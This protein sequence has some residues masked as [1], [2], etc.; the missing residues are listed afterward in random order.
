MVA[1]EAT[2][3]DNSDTQCKFTIFAVSDKDEL[4]FITGT[5]QFK[6]NKVTFENSGFPIRTGVQIIAARVGEQTRTDDLIY[7]DDRGARVKQLMRD[8]VTTLWREKTLS[9]EAPSGATTFPAFVTTV[10]VKDIH[11][12]AVGSGFPLE[13]TSAPVH[14]TVNDRVCALSR[15]STTF[16]TDALGQV[17]IVT[18]ADDTLAAPVFEVTVR[19]GDKSSTN[20]VFAGQRV[21]ERLGAFKSGSD[22]ANA[23]AVDGTPV[24]SDIERQECSEGFAASGELLKS[25]PG[26]ITNLDTDAKALVGDTAPLTEK[27][28]AYDTADKAQQSSVADWIS[29]AWTKTTK[30]I[31]DALEYLRSAV[32]ATLKFAFKMVG[33]AIKFAFTIAGKAISFVIDTLDHFFPAFTSFLRHT[34]KTGM[35]KLVKLLGYR[36]DVTRI[37]QTQEVL[38]AAFS[39]SKSKAN[40]FMKVNK[41]AIRAGFDLARDTI[42]DYI[43]DD[44]PAPKADPGSKSILGWLFDNPIIKFL[45]RFNP[46]TVIIEAASEAMGEEFGEDFRFPDFS[47]LV[48]IF[49]K[50]LPEGL[51]EQIDNIMRLLD[52]FQ[53]RWGSFKNNPASAL[54]E[55]RGL[56]GD[57]FWT[58]FDAIQSFILTLWEVLTLV[59]DQLFELL[60]GAWK[61]PG[62]TSVFESFTG[63]EFSLLNITSFAVAGYLNLFVGNESNLP[64]DVLGRP[65]LAINRIKDEDLDM[66]RVFKEAFGILSRGKDAQYPGINMYAAKQGP[67]S[68]KLATTN[69]ATFGALNTN[70]NGVS[71]S[72][73]KPSDHKRKEPDTK[74]P[75]D[76][77]NYKVPFLFGP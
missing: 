35:E 24:F 47:A 28:Y 59:F 56:L 12:E 15:Q 5:R 55:F 69:L 71:N 72:N 11:S 60:G 76:P 67:P 9:F 48:N 16:T 23:K 21:M 57:I 62:V 4:H 17:T 39:A 20:K 77:A 8:P 10:S 31:G 65:D 29:N 38:I 13:I 61:I 74:T 7:L 53:T 6:G 25:V 46:F 43:R 42:D 70:S 2:D 14:V 64:F 68:A 75:R 1:A 50:A 49:T 26:M 41:G 36:F 73:A 45:M 51:E 63:Q 54:N 32:K 33:K 66:R 40:T 34:I 27:V 58:L 30:F 37:K 3:P 18:P 44:R 22:L 52:S 19:N